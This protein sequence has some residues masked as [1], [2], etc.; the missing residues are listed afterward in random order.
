[1]AIYI[2]IFVHGKEFF[3]TKMIFKLIAFFSHLD[4]KCIIFDLSLLK[5]TSDIINQHIT[6]FNIGRGLDGLASRH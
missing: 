2:F 4:L 6:K 5:L 3:I 1:M